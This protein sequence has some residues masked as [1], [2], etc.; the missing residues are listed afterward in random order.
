M[1]QK[2]IRFTSAQVVRMMLVKIRNRAFNP[3]HVNLLGTNAVIIPNEFWR[4][5]DPVISAGFRARYL[6]YFALAFCTE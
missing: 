3:V 5:L 1:C 4:A 6:M 2:S